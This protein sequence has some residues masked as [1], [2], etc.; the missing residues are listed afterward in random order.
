MSGG[1][2]R[3]LP[4]EPKVAKPPDVGAVLGAGKLFAVGSY[5]DQQGARFV[6]VEPEKVR[7]FEPVDLEV[8]TMEPPKIVMPLPDPGPMLRFSD[9]LQ[10]LDGSIPAG[11][12]PA[13]EEAPAEEGVMDAG[14]GE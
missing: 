2:P 14:G 8:P 4:D 1:E 7:I 12:E 9:Q 11:A 6:F 13:A 5:W 10:R 3:E